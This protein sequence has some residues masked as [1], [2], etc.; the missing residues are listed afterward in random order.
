MRRKLTAVGPILRLPAAK[1]MAV[2]KRIDLQINPSDLYFKYQRKKETR[3]E[4]KFTGKPDPHHF[5]RDDLY[6]VLPMFKA[7]ME[8]LGTDD[9]R[10][11]HQLEE[12][13]IYNIPISI[14][15]REQVF[16]VLVGCMRDIM[17]IDR[18]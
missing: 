5:D 12:V 17:G 13:L 4:P 14:N 16:D 6:E 2:K 15:T 10:V 9:G 3:D 7:V 18:Q 11:L 1:A 8:A